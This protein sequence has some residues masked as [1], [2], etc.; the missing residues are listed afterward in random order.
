[1]SPAINTTISN[2]PG[3]TFYN[4]QGTDQRGYWRTDGSPDIGA[5]ERNASKRVIIQEI[6]FADTNNQFIE[7]YVPRNSTPL[8]LSNFVV[9]THAGVVHTFTTNQSSLQ[10]GEAL[11]LFPQ[12][13][14]PPSL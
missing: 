14:P 6:L 5:F 8:N 4:T 7:F 2:A 1:N 3:A 10:P 9:T 12:N 13:A 11:V